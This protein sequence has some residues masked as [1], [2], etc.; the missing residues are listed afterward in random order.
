MELTE[1]KQ[2]IKSKSQAAVLEETVPPPSPQV[3]EVFHRAVELIGRRWTGAVIQVMLAGAQRFSEI[4]ASVPGISDRLLA[5][6]LK[7]LEDESVL[8]RDVQG[9]RPPQVFY[10]LTDKGRGL[11]PVLDSISTWAHRWNVGEQTEPFAGNP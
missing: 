1:V 8:S 11:A 6:R 10:R 7:E 9:G 5:E 2:V 3:C 4:R